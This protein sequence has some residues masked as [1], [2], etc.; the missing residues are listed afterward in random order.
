MYRFMN[1]YKLFFRYID[2]QGVV[3]VVDKK[4]GVVTEVIFRKSVQN[5]GH[6]HVLI[7]QFDESGE[8][9]RV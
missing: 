9:L 5:T 6:A 7:C 3:A 2:N 1:L 4:G 8:S